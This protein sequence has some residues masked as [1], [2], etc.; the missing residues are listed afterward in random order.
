MQSVM[1]HSF[2]R[3]PM[4]DIQRSSFNRSFGHKTT[5]DAGLL[6][7][8]MWDIAY[9]GDTYN[10]DVS[11][12][13]RLATPEFPIMD[14]MFMDVHFFATPIRQL[15]DSFRE[16]MGERVNPID[17]PTDLVVPTL[18]FAGAPV[19]EMS[20]FDYLGLPL[21]YEEDGSG[22]PGNL[23]PVSAL[24]PRAYNHI[25]NE[26]Y[27]DQNLIDSLPLPQG[28]GTDNAAANYAVRKRG[29]R[30]DYFTACLPWPQKS[31]NPVTLALA[32][33]A[34]V[35]L[36]AP[37]TDELVHVSN[38][39]DSDNDSL[40]GTSII[41]AGN[42]AGP[43]ITGFPHATGP[44]HMGFDPTT[45]LAGL[46]DLTSVSAFTVNQIREAVK[47][48]ELLEIDAR[49]GTRYA[50]IIKAHFGVDF[51]DITY[52]PEYLGGTSVPVNIHPV[53]Q[54]SETAATPQG[55]L[56]AFGTVGMSGG[57]F[58]KSFTEHCIIMAIASVRADLTYQDGIHRLWTD[59]TR[60][61]FFW[62]ALANLGEQAVLK[63]EIYYDNSATDL[64][65]FGYIPRYDHL[66]YAKSMITGLF[67]SDATGTLHNWHLSQDLDSPPDLDQSFIEENPPIDRVIEVPSQPHFI[68]DFFFN[69]QCARPMPMFAVP[70][71]MSHF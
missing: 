40:L 70:G 59:Q 28:S 21:G 53:A 20:L 52:R 66:R 22:N 46:A 68:A 56:A 2:S 12:F 69:M 11:C 32:G 34:P 45:Q 63:R 37:T 49:G 55:N 31:D 65:V 67:R 7:P 6:I 26:W 42:T 1:S 4:I 41:D 38:W 23:S 54:T 44:I 24:P 71:F 3:A 15:W 33:N 27:R 50:E 61:D 25:Y 18:S 29:K 57:G 19:T 43:S 58:T 13:A 14:N 9:P 64:E 16:F 8:I 48:Q 10:V 62:P 17:D 47:V 35:S 36:T 30:H 60:Y 39:Y 51:L 5:F